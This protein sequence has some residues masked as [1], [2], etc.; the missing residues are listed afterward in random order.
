MVNAVVRQSFI[1]PQLTQLTP[2][3]SK[4]ISAWQKQISK[5]DFTT[6]SQVSKTFNTETKLH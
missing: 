3:K 5:V 1:K 2:T 4:N 6:T